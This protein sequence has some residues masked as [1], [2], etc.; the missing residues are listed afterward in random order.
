MDNTILFDSSKY[1]T[2]WGEV[3]L[4][5]SPPDTQQLMHTNIFH[6]YFGGAEANCAVLLSQLGI[7][8]QLMTVL[9]DNEL[10]KAALRYFRGFGINMD[11][12]MFKNDSRL[13]LYFFEKGVGLRPPRLIYDR[14]HSAFAS[15]QKDSINW[16]HV[17]HNCGWFHTTGI[18]LSLSHIL[19]EET[20]KACNEVKQNNGIVSCDVNYRSTLWKD[21]NHAKAVMHEF[22][23]KV[24]VLIGNEDHIKNLLLKENITSYNDIIDYLFTQ[25]PNL[26]LILITH[27]F[28]TNASETEVGALASS[29]HAATELKV[30]KVMH[31]VDRVGAGDAMAAAFIYSFINGNSLNYC[32]DFALAAGAL[33][34]TIDGDS[35]IVNETDIVTVLENKSWQLIR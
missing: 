11:C 25:Y 18:T 17:L 32:V 4:R 19:Y 31:V 33:A 8:T 10:G 28:T 5:L 24:D 34:H 16:D 29:R 26:K 21:I 23:K 12:V 30:R 14:A 22:V 15:L 27:R 6:S 9:P 35:F 20:V 2:G 13:G 3:L 1:F 7:K